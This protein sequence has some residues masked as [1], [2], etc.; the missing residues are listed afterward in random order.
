MTD[1]LSV[2][3]YNRNR[4]IYSPLIEHNGI[5]CGFW[6]CG[7]NYQNKTG[8]Y[9]TYPPSYMKRIKLLF[10]NAQ[11][12]LHLFSGVVEKGIFEN[13]TTMDINPEIKPD[14]ENRPAIIITPDVVGDA[15]EVSSYFA[16]NTFDLILA[17]PPYNKNHIRYDTNPVNKRKVVK[18]AVTILEPGGYMVWLDTII[19]I[20]AKADGWALRG[21]IGLVQSTNHAT[22]VITILK[23]KE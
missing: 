5:I 13:E 12:V 9:G 11:K 6:L 23:K 1:H 21:T 16:E 20:W 10:P 22:R 3:H 15:A 14:P 8:Y 2:D 4:S 7:N 19:P 17:D 18:Q